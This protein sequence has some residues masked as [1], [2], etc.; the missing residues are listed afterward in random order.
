MTELSDKPLNL[1]EMSIDDFDELIGAYHEA[2]YNL[3]EQYRAETM[4][5][6]DDIVNKLNKEKKEYECE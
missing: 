4:Y 5:S 3:L 2:F 1:E 6:A